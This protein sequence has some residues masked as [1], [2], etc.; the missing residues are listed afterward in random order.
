MSSP[1]NR[2][3]QFRSYS[4]YH[5]LAM[6][7][8]SETADQLAQ[9]TS[10]D[11][12]YHATP[13]TIISDGR[14]N[15]TALGPYAPKRLANSTNG[16]KYVILI[17]GSTDAAYVIDS[18]HWTSST[19][20]EAA[21]N[22]RA[23]SIAVEGNIHVSEPK[24]V[25]FLDQIVQCSIAL[26]VDSAQIV[27]VLKTFFVGI[28]HDDNG[29]DVP[30]HISD[31]PPVNFIVYD[32]TGSFTEQGGMYEMQF[33]A[34]GHGAARL[35]Q[36]SKAVNAM[37][38]T[39][40]PSLESTLKALETQ[41]NDNYEKYFDCVIDQI[42]AMDGDT[43]ALVASLNRVKYV[44]EVGADYQDGVGKYTV[45]NQAQQ[46]KN[47]AGC[48]DSAQVTFPAQ[49]SIET[50]ISTIMQMSPEVQR[51]AGR[52]SAD[53]SVKYEYKIHTAVETKRVAGTDT[54]QLECTVY[55]RVD[56]FMTPK[57]I[58]SNVA[59]SGSSAFDTL[60]GD[61]DVNDPSYLAI[62]NNIITFDYMYTGKNIDILEFDMKMNYGL[63][64]LQTATLANTFKSQ[65]ERAPN[66]TMQPATGDVNRNRFEGAPVQ[67]F[68]FFGSQIKTPNLQNSQNAGNTIQS[69]YTMNKH[70]SLEVSEASMKITGNCQ[71]L[72]TVNQT[73]S[74]GYVVGSATR[75]PSADQSDSTADFQDWSHSPAFVKVNIKMPRTNDDFALFTGTNTDATGST[76]YARDFWFDGY[77][78]C[79]GIEHNFDGGEF[80][81]ELKMI[82]LPKKSAVASVAGKN[83]S[84]QEVNITDA[85]GSCYDNQIPCGPQAST[86]AGS[87]ATG[88][89]AV[90]EMPPSKS[91]APTNTADAVSTQQNSAG[92][93]NV[94]LWDS[95]DTKP[96]VK[97]AIIDAAAKYTVDVVSLAQVCYQ[98]SKFIASASNPRSSAGGLFQFIDA[99]WIGEVKQGSI[100]GLKDTNVRNKFVP[101]WA[102]Y[103]G[104]AYL[105]QNAK[106][107][108]STNVGDLYLAHFAGPDVAKKIIAACNADG[109]KALCSTVIGDVAFAKIVKANSPYVYN[110]MTASSFRFF[111]TNI[112]AKTLKTYTPVAGSSSV[113]TTAATNTT[114]EVRRDAAT[115]LASA[116]NCAVQSTAAAATTP[117]GPTAQTAAA[118]PPVVA[119]AAAPVA[120]V[121][122]SAAA[123]APPTR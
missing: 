88:A 10:L 56:R 123:G 52:G 11:V 44:I 104:A 39:A 18:A 109:G 93:S 32:V 57:A 121:S 106:A 71:L 72:G 2:L 3:S 61:V 122:P 63:A 67:K 79:Y 38:I 34:A 43:I 62:R 48:A 81:Q 33:V 108:G 91:T 27:Y 87:G 16:G 31:I 77:Y 100:L 97:A 83:N 25:A 96:D 68:I 49:S 53:D 103:A 85:V 1:Q 119:K 117:C 12:W 24:G 9:E 105:Q 98:E 42:R 54:D 70:A 5:V 95:P 102:A 22:D 69:M 36:Y 17:N 60:A 14:T 110:G 21:P 107:I 92:L 19:G 75:T 47:T 64:Y 76:D 78:Y 113:P 40:G 73:T 13:D 86:P 35:S 8:C 116:Q 28:R 80:T 20:A 120:A 41:I 66:R 29:D 46:F 23:T 55:Y 90:A 58:A 50:A 82:G 7:D 45:T 101:K 6:C 114:S 37:S 84:T 115:S 94:K 111:A 15:T 51:E 112:M 99:T 74:A 26:G 118:P 59:F 4:Y 65:L 30:E 89:V